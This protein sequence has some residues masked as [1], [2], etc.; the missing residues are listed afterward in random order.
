MPWAVA[1]GLELTSIEA[2]LEE[3]SVAI[4]RV[5][6]RLMVAGYKIPRMVSF[7]NSVIVVLPVAFQILHTFADTLK[8]PMASA[9]QPIPFPAMFMR[10]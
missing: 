10:G 7:S 2:L 8:A 9:R 4:D 1:V 5:N 3:A 6:V